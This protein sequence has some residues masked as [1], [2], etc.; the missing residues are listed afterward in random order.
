MNFYIISR[1]LFF[2]KFGGV[3]FLRVRSGHFLESYA[4]FWGTFCRSGLEAGLK[5][6][7]AC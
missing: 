2:E 3:F 1:A 5:T 6:G 7:V 4:I